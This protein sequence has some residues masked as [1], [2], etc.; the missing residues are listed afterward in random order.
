MKHTEFIASL[1]DLMEVERTELATVDRALAKAGM[2]QLSRGR[3]H[4]DVTLE[5]GVRLVCAWA[6]SQSLTLAAQ[7]VDRLEHC[8]LEAQPPDE[9]ALTPRFDPEFEKIFGVSEQDLA[10][11]SFLE[12]MFRITRHIGSGLP[13]TKDLE[14]LWIEIEKGGAPEIIY[15]RFPVVGRVSFRKLHKTL[16]F[17]PKT[18]RTRPPKPL[19]KI[20]TSISWPVLKWIFDVTEGA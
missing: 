16:D 15:T 4:P 3:Y 13:D 5:E 11:L 8:T 1:A 18:Q 14:D 17:D 7:D 12:V 2:R 6:G 10:N 20:T 9:H 19:V